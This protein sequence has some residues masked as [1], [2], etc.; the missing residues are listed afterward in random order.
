[1]KNKIIVI[2]LS[3]LITSLVLTIPV[4][5]QEQ[6]LDVIIQS[7]QQ[8]IKDLEKQIAELQAQVELAKKA[9]IRISEISKF[10]KTLSR[11]ITGDEVKELQEFLKQFPDIYPEGLVTGYFGSLTEN[12]VKKWQEQQGIESVGIVGPKTRAKL[13]EVIVS[14]GGGGGG[15]PATP[16]IPS[17]G[18]GTPTTPATPATPPA[19]SSGG[20]GSPATP[21]TP[22]TPA[23]PSSSG[24]TP[25]TPAVPAIP[26]QP[27]QDITPPII[28]NIQATNITETSATITW[29][30]DE[31]SSSE[32]WY[33]ASSTI[34]W[35]TATGTIAV[36]VTDTNNV[37]SHSIGLSGLSS[38]KIYYYIVVSKDSAGNTATSTEQSFTTSTPP[39]PVS[40]W[41]NNSLGVSGE[42]QSTAWNGNGYGVVYGWNGKLYFI[43]LD[44]NGNKLG[45]P[46]IVATAPNYIFWTNIV[47]DGARYGV[48]WPEANPSN[49][50][51]ATLGVDG[52][53]LSNIAVTA[54]TDNASTERPTVLWTGNEYILVWSGGWPDNFNN[55]YVPTGIIYFSKIASDGQT[56]IINK[57]K[58]ITSGDAR[59]ANGPIVSAYLNGS[60]IGVLWQDIRNSGDSNN[61]ALYFN[62]LDNNGDKLISNDV[63]VSG[64]GRVG[65]PQIFAD[66]ASYIVFWRESTATDVNANSIYVAKLDSAGNKVLANQ[67]LNTKGD[68]EIR[69]SVTKTADGYGIAWTSFPESKIYFKSINLSASIMVDNELISTISGS[70]DGA[71]VVWGNDKY[72]IVWRNIQNNQS[73]LYFGIK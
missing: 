62:I 24:G 68:N 34:H 71:Y 70:N 57:K 20:G 45:E 22:A 56:I 59:A 15:T 2:L 12:A 6:N 16:A 49:L 10:T 63:K 18:T 47:W 54:G 21:A 73:Q 8:K 7:L 65:S 61:P 3:A 13:N 19:S 26:A 41:S 53:V 9:E 17:Q 55:P 28:S 27:S 40:S 60:S 69:P 58:S 1:M 31:L 23:I 64:A 5:A 39:P 14:G 42:Y 35:Y 37:T 44:S 32:V 30:T 33:A 72:G 67:N 46:I 50:R 51:F 25:A 66:G 38:G 43:K 29:T 36:K 11:G 52:N 48:V 4:S